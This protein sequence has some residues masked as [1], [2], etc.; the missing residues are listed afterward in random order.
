MK[1]HWFGSLTDSMQS[2]L[3]S[4]VQRIHNFQLITSVA[5]SHPADLKI[6]YLFNKSQK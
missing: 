2:K 5:I 3:G 4:A 1:E 6:T